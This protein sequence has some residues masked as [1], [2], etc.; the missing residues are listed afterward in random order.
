[1]KW[2]LIMLIYGDPALLHHVEFT[3]QAACENAGTRVQA[4]WIS[5]HGG[6]KSTRSVSQ[7]K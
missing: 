7:R 6:V 3:N 2:I 5:P 1:M 4:T